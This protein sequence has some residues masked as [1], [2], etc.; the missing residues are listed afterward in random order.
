VNVQIQDRNEML[1]KATTHVAQA[2]SMLRL[3]FISDQSDDVE[4][5]AGLRTLVERCETLLIDENVS[6]LNFL[7]RRPVPPRFEHE[8]VAAGVYTV[9]YLDETSERFLIYKTGKVDDLHEAYVSP[10][11]PDFAYSSPLALLMA[12]CAYNSTPPGGRYERV[13]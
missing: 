7:G 13:P 3:A 6:L 2:L 4:I 9:N 10:S 5:Q 11:H 1:A 12:M 8:P